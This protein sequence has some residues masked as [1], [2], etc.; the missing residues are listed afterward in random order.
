MKRWALHQW[1]P[2]FLSLLVLFWIQTVQAA[3]YPV[4]VTDASGA[5]LTFTREPARVVSLVPAATEILLA[6]GCGESVAALTY[7]DATL[8]GAQGKP[9]VG[10]FFSPSLK[11]IEAARP[12]LLIVSPHHQSL[13]RHFSASG[14]SVLVLDT[15]SL[16]EAEENLRLLGRSFSREAEAEKIIAGNQDRMQLI[17]E[18]VAQIPP[19]RRKRVMRFMGRDKVMAPGDDSFQNELIRSAGGIPPVWGK[20]GEIVPVTLEAWRLFDPQVLYGCG[21]DREV[22]QAFFSR[23]EWQ[24]VEA[25]KKGQIHYFPCDLTCRAATHTGDF[26]TWL[27][28]LI[29]TEEFADPGQEVRPSGVTGSRPLK[30]DLPYIQGARITASTIQDFPNK[31][32]II[33]FTSPQKIV[34]TL[35]GPRDGISVVGNH[36]SPP[37]AWSLDHHLGLEGL[38]RRVYGALG[39]SPERASYMFTGADMDN[40]A[41]R[42]AEFKELNVT[43]LVTAG[44]ET[45]AV[46][47]SRDRGDYY[48]PGTINI[49][50]LTNR[51]LSP[52]AMT[53]AV[54]DATEAKTAALWDLD[55]RSSFT[56]RVN[57]ATGTGTDNIIV[58]Q[59]AGVPL[60]HAG[61][62]TKLGELIASAVYAGV[63]EAIYKQNGIVPGRKIFQRLQ[64]RRLELYALSSQAR[65][66]CGSPDRDYAALLE[67][68]LLE[69]TVAGFM[70]SALAISDAYERGLIQDL[71][72]FRQWCRL[73]ASEIAGLPVRMLM[74]P[75][76]ASDLPPV[77][78]LAFNA[79]L[80]GLQSRPASSAT[81]PKAP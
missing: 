24:E 38:Q 58:V 2:G 1:V 77:I 47:M 26:T 37:P 75:L 51:S 79:L 80:S 3:E 13:G 25:V 78:R 31:T 66:A 35:E 20:P 27:A 6:L 56:S 33:E 34:S 19:E 40:L 76:G 54:I 43:A 28:S 59:G 64:E 60:D 22:A 42:Q 15:R 5:T 57:P 8:P 50:L 74:N 62:H 10:G 17:R 61:G 55:I 71:E 81:G 53:R 39:Q 11:A 32:L 36:Y 73:T 41:V 16:I 12:D 49:I 63:Q 52:R 14:V 21:D 68:A 70:E 44:V 65:L 29:Y 72:P 45:N 4:I 69:P 46:R 7:H 18:K 23:P 30:L 67:E 48:E 9:I